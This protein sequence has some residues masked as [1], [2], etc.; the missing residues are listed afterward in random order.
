M[1]LQRIS[2]TNIIVIPNTISSKVHI[3]LM[4]DSCRSQLCALDN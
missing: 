3:L 2:V 1:T 4:H